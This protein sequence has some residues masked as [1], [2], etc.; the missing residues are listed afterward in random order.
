MSLFGGIVTFIVVWWIVLFT[1]LPWGIRS[2]IESDADTIVRGSDAGAP[3]KPKLKIKFLITTI[4][5]L[6]I[7]GF[8]AYLFYADIIIIRDSL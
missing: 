1:V 5:A 4:I 8:F 3:K 6:I 2:Q 7:W